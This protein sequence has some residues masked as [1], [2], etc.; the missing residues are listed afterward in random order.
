MFPTRAASDQI[1]WLQGG[2]S[3]VKSAPKAKTWV[4][5]HVHASLATSG[6]PSPHL[7]QPEHSFVGYQC[8]D[9]G[10]WLQHQHPSATQ[11]CLES[12]WSRRWPQEHL[13]GWKCYPSAEHLFFLWQ[14]LAWSTPCGM[15]TC[16]PWGS[17]P[18]ATSPPA[19]PRPCTAMGRM[20][21][22]TERTRRTAVS[23]QPLARRADVTPRPGHIRVWDHECIRVE[24]A[25]PLGATAA[26][27]VLDL[28]QILAG[29]PARPG[30]AAKSAPGSSSSHRDSPG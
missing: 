26:Q 23:S 20:T 29:S 7:L 9:A 25:L 27:E 24:L 12:H 3:A 21:A 4:L 22:A 19:C 18:V 1:S 16:V 13:Q 14:S 10:P 17:S 5:R 15:S 8:G 30:T 28:L 2:V 11:P 6:T